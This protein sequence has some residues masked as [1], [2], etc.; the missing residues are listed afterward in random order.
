MR[1]F[2]FAWSADWLYSGFRR[3][4]KITLKVYPIFIT[5]EPDLDWPHISLRCRI[6][7]FK[8]SD[9]DEIRFKGRAWSILGNFQRADFDFSFSP[10]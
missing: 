7:E 3:R 2:P 1:A 4:V 9:A 8:I 6:A 10:K 5:P